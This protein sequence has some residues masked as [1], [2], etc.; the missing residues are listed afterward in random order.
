[1]FPLYGQELLE[2]LSFFQVIL[3]PQLFPQYRKKVPLRVDRVL[4]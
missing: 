2:I 1:M 3:I 4:A